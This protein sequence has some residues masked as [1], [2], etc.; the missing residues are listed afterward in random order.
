MVHGDVDGLMV[1][2]VKQNRFPLLSDNRPTASAGSGSTSAQKRSGLADDRGAKA[3]DG[4]GEIDGLVGQQ[5]PSFRCQNGHGDLRPIEPAFNGLF[6]D[7]YAIGANANFVG[8]RRPFAVVS[9]KEADLKPDN[10]T[11]ENIAHVS[12]TPSGPAQQPRLRDHFAQ[13]LPP[14]RKTPAPPLPCLVKSRGSRKPTKRVLV[15]RH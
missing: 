5:L 12:K 1:P 9:A 7:E 8:G 6:V 2:P 14:C 11:R 13:Q 4:G 15:N 3:L 10:V